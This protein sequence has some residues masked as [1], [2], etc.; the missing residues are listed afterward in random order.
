MPWD[1]NES[2]EISQPLA[3]SP[4]IT[5]S[6]ADFATSNLQNNDNLLAP[7]RFSPRGQQAQPG[8]RGNGLQQQGFGNGPVSRSGSG[9]RAGQ[10]RRKSND[11][12]RTTANC[13]V[14]E[15]DQSQQGRS[16]P[17]VLQGVSARRGINPNLLPSSN[18]TDEELTESSMHSYH[19]TDTR[20]LLTFFFRE[21]KTLVM[22]P[23]EFFATRKD[24][25]PIMEPV[26]FMIIASGLSGLLVCLGGHP[27][28]G[29]SIF[30]GTFAFVLLGALACST[31]L[32]WLA[33]K[34][35]Y[36]TMFR[37]FGFSQA[38]FVLAW[39]NLG[40]IP[41]G[42]YVACGYSIYLC[43]TGLE[44]IYKLDQKWSAIVAI[45]ITVVLRLLLHLVNL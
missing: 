43:M 24:G 35:K 1:R 36:S 15:Y 11:L 25:D 28:Q 30:L 22:D 20:F 45:T 38:P 3:P 12:Y 5:A 17:R 13:E 26:V 8:E 2:Q 18:Y 41:I 33:K 31:T 4:P 23:V 39:I 10:R 19:S 29:L 27:L 6:H 16:V 7:D 34:N 9:S 37:I 14:D 21:A 32:D 42:W 40:N 44:M